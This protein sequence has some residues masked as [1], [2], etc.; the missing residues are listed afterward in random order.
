[1]PG[2]DGIELLRLV[3]R[4]VPKVKV[5]VLS[6]QEECDF[7]SR[8][9][10]AGANGYLM[11]DDAVAELVP[12]LRRVLCDGLHMSAQLKAHILGAADRASGS[13]SAAPLDEIEASSGTAAR[14]PTRD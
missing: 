13:R 5:L 1:M 10:H 12:A 14:Q 2:T 3:K 11:K 7:G 9:L 4:S 8:A 6:M